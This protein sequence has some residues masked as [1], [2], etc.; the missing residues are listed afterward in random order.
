GLEKLAHVAESLLVAVRDGRRALDRPTQDVLLRALDAFGQA[1]A[2]ILDGGEFHADEA[3]LRS[4]VET[5]ALAR[6]E[7]ATAEPPAA[8]AIQPDGDLYFDQATLFAL[9]ELFEELLP[10][11]ADA[12]AGAAP[13]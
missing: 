10:S 8:P 11:I 13:P 1:R 12:V 4:L 6:A 2:R 9:A 3:L 5:D 7:S